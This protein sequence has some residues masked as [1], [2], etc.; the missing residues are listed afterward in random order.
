[1]NKIAISLLA[2]AALSTGVFAGNDA[3]NGYASRNLS[4]AVIYSSP[5]TDM[6]VITDNAG[7][8]TGSVGAIDNSFS[9]TVGDREAGAASH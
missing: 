7:I 4:D 3:S 1:M 2:L 5:A 8:V 6:S 9:F